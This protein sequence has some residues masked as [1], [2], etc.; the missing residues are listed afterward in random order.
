MSSSSSSKR[1]WP[2]M[3][4]S[5]PT[6]W[7]RHCSDIAAAGGGLAG[8]GGCDQESSRSGPEPK[9]RWNPKPE[10]IRILESIFNS[11]MVNPSRDEIRN[12]RA[13]LQEFGQLGDANVFYWFQN[14]KSRTKHKLRQLQTSSA[15]SPPLPP[16]SPPQLPRKTHTPLPPPPSPPPLPLI[17]PSA[18]GFGSAGDDSPASLLLAQLMADYPPQAA[19]KSTVFVS[20][21]MALEVAAAAHLNVK[22]AFGDDAV[23][24]HYPSGEPLL[25]DEWGVTVNPLQDGAYYILVRA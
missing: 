14:R 7:H 11:G 10:Q 16:P 19:A 2:S 24:I 9:A 13:K 20:G 12:I 8:R 3:F 25:T 15:L 1:H 18:C 21:D 5:K 22:A 23:L 4:K 6:P 17:D